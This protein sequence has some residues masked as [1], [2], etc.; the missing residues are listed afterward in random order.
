MTKLREVEDNP[1]NCRLSVSGYLAGDKMENQDK[2]DQY[3]EEH[4]KLL[5]DLARIAK[6]HP[7]RMDEL[8]Q[9]MLLS[10]SLMRS[11]RSEIV[12]NFQDTAKDAEAFLKACQT[13]EINPED[14]IIKYEDPEGFKNL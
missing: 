3:L 9:M 14:F 8:R 13:G 11:D 5:N 7:E 6:D 10:A 4:R 12:E 1:A 2:I